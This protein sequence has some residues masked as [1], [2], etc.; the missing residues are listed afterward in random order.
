MAKLKVNRGT[1]YSITFNYQKDGVAASLSGA[2]VRFT[3]KEDEYDSDAL[4]ATA[5]IRKN[6]TSHTDAGGG[7]TTI[8]LTPTDTFITP[9]NYYWDIKVQEID[10]T[11]YKTAEGRFEVDG[12]PTNRTT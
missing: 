6:V 7:Q 9:G 1:T 2:T 8:T 3:V 11:V 4:D 10:G 5:L 12:S